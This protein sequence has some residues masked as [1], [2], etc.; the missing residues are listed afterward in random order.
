MLR[1]IPPYTFVW[2]LWS[3]SLTGELDPAW[4]TPNLEMLD[5]RDNSFEGVAWDIACCLPP[6]VFFLCFC[7]WSVQVAHICALPSES[8]WL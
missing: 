2:R 6:F 7:S 4:N 8:D 5:L 3:R 1:A